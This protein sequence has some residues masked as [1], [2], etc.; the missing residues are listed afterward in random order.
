M[1]KVPPQ[2]G[3]IKMDYLVNGIEKLGD[4]LENI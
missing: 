3:R 1:I 4:H 2:I